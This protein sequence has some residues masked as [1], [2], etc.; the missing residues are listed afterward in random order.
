MACRSGNY[1]LNQI[2]NGMSSGKQNSP[3]SSRRLIS[4][5]EFKNIM[6]SQKVHEST[7]ARENDQVLDQSKISVPIIIST[8][9]L[10]AHASPGQRKGTIDIEMQNSS[11][12]FQNSIGNNNFGSVVRSLGSSVREQMKI[13]ATYSIEKSQEFYTS[14]EN[15]SF[16]PQGD[17][18][19]ITVV[20]K[21]LLY[22][23]SYKK[24]IGT[25]FSEGKMQR[26]DSNQKKIS[27]LRNLHDTILVENEC[28]KEKGS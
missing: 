13:P 28:L 18:S 1:H 6:S 9:P 22:Q 5:D 21:S 19:S 15:Q 26:N 10:T 24:P 4:L 27:T 8:E 3:K 17:R 25:K 2:V 12:I 11:S 23:G 14:R 20:K 16:S 7:Q